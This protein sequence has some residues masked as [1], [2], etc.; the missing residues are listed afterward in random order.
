MTQA[1]QAVCKTDQVKRTWYNSYSFPL[2][3]QFSFKRGDQYNTDGFSFS[4]LFIRLWSLDSFQFELSFNVDS[5]WGI[6][7]TAII[8]YLRIV[9]CIPCPVK[10]QM[11]TQRNLWR[12]PK[13]KTL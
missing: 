12:K 3:P 5:H 6:G 11:W 4:W 7:V 8:P 10:W 13:N 2:V 1:E 9:V